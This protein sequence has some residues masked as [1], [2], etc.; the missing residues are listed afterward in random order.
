[1]VKTSG[2]RWRFFLLRFS[3]PRWPDWQ[4]RKYSV[5]R[6]GGGLAQMMRPCPG[7]AATPQRCRAEP[8]PM[9]PRKSLRHGPRLCSAP[10]R[11]A[12][13]GARELRSVQVVKVFC[14]TA[15]AVSFYRKPVFIENNPM[16]SRTVVDFKQDFTGWVKRTHPAKFY[17][18]AIWRGA[19]GGL[20]RSAASWA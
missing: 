16:H 12:A 9:W 10:K 8:G 19:G 1:M 7:R 5:G 14:P 2:L 15:Q 18:A 3:E 6:E 4:A 11:C 13:S 17:S 20:A